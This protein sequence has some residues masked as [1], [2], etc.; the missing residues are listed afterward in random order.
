MG[1]ESLWVP[2]A[3]P[4]Q[5]QGSPTPPPSW[6]A[7]QMSPSVLHI[8]ASPLATP[9]LAPLVF[10]FGGHGRRQGCCFGGSGAV[11]EALPALGGHWGYSVDAS[12]TTTKGQKCTQRMCD[13]HTEKEDQTL[14][15]TILGRIGT[16]PSA[17]RLLTHRRAG[18][19]KRVTL[20]C[21][22]VPCTV[23]VKPQ[24][25]LNGKHVDPSV[26]VGEL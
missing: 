25:M 4:E 15:F 1:R 20:L 11:S 3:T 13:T 26:Q 6:D 16:A 12:R 23:L 19:I 8:W 24:L 9:S 7:H 21:M 17:T 2:R 10:I 18:G 14:R 5:P 22:V